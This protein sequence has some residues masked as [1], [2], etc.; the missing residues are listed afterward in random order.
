MPLPPG[1]VSDTCAVTP[2]SRSC[3]VS[4]NP[5]FMDSAITSVATPAATPITE[6]AV[7]SRSTAG[8]YGDRRYLRAT[9]HS[10]FIASAVCGLLR[11]PCRL[12]PQLREQNHIADRRR[13]RKQHGQA[14]NADPFPCRRRHAVAQRPYII[15]IHLLGRLIPA[16][17]HLRSKA[18]FLF[19]RIV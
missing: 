4:R 1:L 2:S 18:P 7:T 8:R 11:S 9:N 17:L 13:V 15:P 12:R 16:T 6:N 5:V 3:S 10:N 19:Y 14:I